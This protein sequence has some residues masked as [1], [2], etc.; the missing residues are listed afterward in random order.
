MTGKKKKKE[1]EKEKEKAAATQVCDSRLVIS[2][3]KSSLA[4]SAAYAA[5]AWPIMRPP[6]KAAPRVTPSISG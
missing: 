6:L 4:Y 1:K 5:L 2:A 3:G